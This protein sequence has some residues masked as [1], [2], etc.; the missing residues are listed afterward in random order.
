[1][2]NAPLERGTSTC[3]QHARCLYACVCVCVCVCVRVCVCAPPCLHRGFGDRN[4][5]AVHAIIGKY[6]CAVSR[7]MLTAQRT[8]QNVAHTG[9]LPGRPHGQCRRSMSPTRSSVG[10]T[11]AFLGPAGHQLVTHGLALRSA[12]TMRVVRADV[13]RT[14]VCGLSTCYGLVRADP[15][16]RYGIQRVVESGVASRCEV[17]TLLLRGNMIRAKVLA[18]VIGMNSRCP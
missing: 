15:S 11:H 8:A 3:D 17:E 1:M 9:A 7:A 10:L 4:C 13:L 16:A 6:C 12:N 2:L 18:I 14:T 5:S